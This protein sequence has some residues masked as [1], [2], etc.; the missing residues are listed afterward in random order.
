M[1]ELKQKLPV[2]TTAAN[3]KHHFTTLLIFAFFITL[4]PAH[5][6]KLFPGLP[7]LSS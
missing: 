3:I 6:A 5:I 1:S 7:L 2:I 4:P